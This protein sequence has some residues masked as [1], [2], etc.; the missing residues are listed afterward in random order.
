MNLNLSLSRQHRITVAI[1]I[2]VEFGRIIAPI[3]LTQP[4][5]NFPS[6]TALKRLLYTCVLLLTSNVKVCQRDKEVMYFGKL[7]GKLTQY[8]RAV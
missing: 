4:K 3:I 1:R 5:S 2:L 6:G 8:H 7:T